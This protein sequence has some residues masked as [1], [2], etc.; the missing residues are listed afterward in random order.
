[1]PSP[2]KIGDVNNI[3]SQTSGWL[4]CG[5]ILIQVG[6][7]QTFLYRGYTVVL[8]INHELILKNSFQIVLSSIIHDKSLAKMYFCRSMETLTW[9]VRMGYHDSAVLCYI[10]DGDSI[11]SNVNGLGCRS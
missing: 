6:E 9:V 4:I 8:E 5:M 11:E 2:L 7:K 3:D 10:W 1:M